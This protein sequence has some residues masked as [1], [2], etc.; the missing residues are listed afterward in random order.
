MQGKSVLCIDMDVDGPG[1]RVLFEI[2]DQQKDCYVQDYFFNSA[3]FDIGNAVRN[4]KYQQRYRDLPGSVH[5]LPATLNYNRQLQLVSFRKIASDL[6]SLVNDIV[7][8]RDLR[9]DIVLIDST[10]G[11]SEVAKAGFAFANHVLMVYRYSRQHLIGTETMIRFFDHAEIRFSLVASVIPSVLKETELIAYND[12]LLD[13]K[14]HKADETIIARI[15]EIERL[16]WNERIL[17]FDQ[18][19]I[20]TCKP[21]ER[22]VFKELESAARVLD[23]ISAGR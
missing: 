2:E 14:K 18:V 16:K 22:T 1:L 12:Y 3:G 21:Q 15:P 13:G 6:E 11:F 8:T 7:E 10:S 23:Q 20:D 5:V 9:P 4:M 19:F 17:Y